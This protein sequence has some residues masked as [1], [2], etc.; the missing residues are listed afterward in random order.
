M[1]FYQL[2]NTAYQEMSNIC[3]KVM[4]PK[5]RRPYIGVV[6]TLTNSSLE[7]IDVLLPLSSP[8]IG[9][10]IDNKNL[11]YFIIGEKYKNLGVVSLRNMIPVRKED[12]EEYNFSESDEKYNI[13]IEKQKRHI[14]VKQNKIKI[15]ASKLYRNLYSTRESGKNSK[16]SDGCTNVFELTKRVMNS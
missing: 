12:Y 14:K 8:K 9:K 15:K 6:I 11:K 1:K 2:K 7:N 4:H 5:T 13:L 10:N 16:L 3:S